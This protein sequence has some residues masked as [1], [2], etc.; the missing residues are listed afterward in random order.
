MDFFCTALT[1]PGVID[2][3]DAG[4]CIL[5]DIL[6]LLYFPPSFHHTICPIFLYG[7]KK[8][9][10]SKSLW[11]L[12]YLPFVWVVGS[13]FV[14]HFGLRPD[15]CCWKFLFILQSQ[16]RLLQSVDKLPKGSDLSK[17]SPLRLFFKKYDPELSSRTSFVV[18]MLARFNSGIIFFKQMHPG[19]YRSGTTSRGPW[20]SSHK[21]ASMAVRCALSPHFE[22]NAIFLDHFVSSPLV[23]DH[24]T[25]RSGTQMVIFWGGG[26]H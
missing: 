13:S 18:G 14:T 1:H 17:Q 7:M 23:N 15:F 22:S 11:F 16:L 12:L 10:T 26:S 9:Y 2:Y 5:E 25:E 21:L 24:P 8:F 6:C 4:P 3:W 20:S 19:K